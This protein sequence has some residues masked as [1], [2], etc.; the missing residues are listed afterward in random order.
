[1]QGKVQKI[2][3]LTPF[4][5]EHSRQQRREKQEQERTSWTRSQWYS[6]GYRVTATDGEAVRSFVVNSTGRVLYLF[7]ETQVVER[8][9]VEQE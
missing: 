4:E 8:D 5:L 2:E 7:D 9:Y 3:G 1:M 6:A